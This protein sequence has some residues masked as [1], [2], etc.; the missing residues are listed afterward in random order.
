MSFTEKVKNELAHLV[1]EDKNS[2]KAELLALLRIGGVFV[3]GMHGSSGL[4]FSTGNNAV[5]RRVLVIL[6]KDF[7]LNPSAMVRQG[8]K[9]RKKNMYTLVVQPSKE[10]MKFIEDLNLHPMKPIEDETRLKTQ[11]EKRAY[12]AGAFLGGGTVN[13]PQGD[14]HLEIV[15]QSSAFAKEIIKVMKSFDLNGK[16]TYRKSDYI[17]YIKEGDAVSGFMQII[18]ASQSYLDFESVRVVKDMRNRINRQ[19]N[20]ET[21]NLQ[22]TVD[23]SVKQME[24]IK[25]LLRYK[26]ILALS[27]EIRKACEIRVA[28]PNASMKELAEMCHISKSGMAHRFR[29]IANMV[30][31]LEEKA[32]K[33]HEK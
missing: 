32:G 26:P 1:R 18:G 6:K 4:E 8:R 33:K 14:Y 23:A 12:L 30:K 10:G 16:I 11:E 15:T 9:L 27:P 22:K 29:R 2:R 31:K 24:N 7:G 20:C 13:R 3:T 25:K 21:A 19:V 17:V 5:A 28:Y